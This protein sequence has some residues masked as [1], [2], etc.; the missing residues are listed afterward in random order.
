MYFYSRKCGHTHTCTYNLRFW[1]RP[2]RNFR[3]GQ[4]D[5]TQSQFLSS[6]VKHASCEHLVCQIR[7][8]SSSILG[9]EENDWMMSFTCAV[10]VCVLI[11]LSAGC[12]R[13]VSQA[14]LSALGVSCD[15]FAAPYHALLSAP[16]IHIH[17]HPL[18]SSW[19]RFLLC[20]ALPA[21]LTYSSKV[22]YRKWK[23]N[24]L[25]KCLTPFWPRT[26]TVWHI[27]EPHW[28]IYNMVNTL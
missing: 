11:C 5:I 14:A 15:L 19:Q 8:H 25:C 26:F 27:K 10:C 2:P 21:W 24:H 4:G 28:S 20:T 6:K 17:L 12:N 7:L 18:Y 9:I 1:S 13:H 23:E 22:N 3:P 16:Y